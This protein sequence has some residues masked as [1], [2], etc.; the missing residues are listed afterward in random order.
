MLHVRLTCLC[1]VSSVYS[2][3]EAEGSDRPGSSE[4]GDTG[5]PPPLDPSVDTWVVPSL[6]CRPWAIRHEEAALQVGARC[7]CCRLWRFCV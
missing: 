2:G 3:R 6:Q 7:F 5:L 4:V 1:T